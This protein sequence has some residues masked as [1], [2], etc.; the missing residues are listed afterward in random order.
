M[1]ASE[2]NLQ[3]LIEGTKQYIVPLFQRTYSWTK[4]EWDILW[5]DLCE[6]SEMEQPRNHFIGS[7]VNMPTTAIP[8]GVT[9]YLLIDGQQRITTLLLILI[10]LRDKA[11]ENGQ[12]EFAEEIH[13]TL[14]VNQYKKD[15][16]DYLRLMPTHIDRHVFYNFIHS[17]E[18]EKSPVSENPVHKAYS[19]FEKKLRQTPIESES[20]KKIIINH[21]SFVSIILDTNDNPYLVFESLNAKGRPLTQAD[22]IKNYFFMRIHIN[23]QEA[24]YQEFWKPMEDRLGDDLTDY[25]RHYQMKEGAVVKQYDVYYSLKDRVCA[26]NALEFL[27]ELCATSAYYQRLLEPENEPVVGIRYYLARLKQLDV[28]TVYPLLIHLYL[29]HEAEKFSTADFVEML[30]TIENFLIRRFVCGIAT[31][32]LNKIF[33]SIIPL[34]QKEYPGKYVTGMKELLQGRGYPGDP[35]FRQRFV[36]SKMYGAG[37]RGSKGK[38]ILESIE[39]S[40]GHKEKVPFDNLT[41][42]HIMPQTL[43][44]WWQDHLGDDWDTVYQLYLHNIGNLTLTAYNTELSNDDFPTK[45]EFYC[46]SH[47]ELNHYFKDVD[48]WKREN[49]EKRADF[50][51]GKAVEIW[52]YFGPAETSSNEPGDVTGMKPQKL[53]ILGNDFQ[54]KNWRDVLE[55]TLNTIADLEPGKFEVLLTEF[56]RLLGKDKNRFRAVRELKNGLYFEV[57]LSAKDIVRFCKQALEITGFN[58]E[59]DWKIQTS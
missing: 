18:N 56:S 37:D 21:L 5:N 47:L 53:S 30:K 29:E 52:P 28:T 6:L 15:S 39:E 58:P 46:D 11:K 7:I 19:F 17:K 34:L 13:N 36:E 40:F 33:P 16:D 10:V 3:T 14:L 41:I 31:N 57:N 1:H 22:L 51:A 23:R 25:I 9:K 32:Q 24:V 45:K 43:S 2:I 55:H 44:G 20:L 35:G 50:L 4:K 48:S 8:E 26:E 38:L 27:G 12:F 42:E 49:I 59:E 54:V